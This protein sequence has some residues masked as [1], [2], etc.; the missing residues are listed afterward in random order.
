MSQFLKQTFASLVGSLAGLILFFGLGTSGLIFLIIAVASRDDGPQVKDKSVLV[1][2]LA[3]TITDT[4]P[5]LSTTEAIG[6]VLGGSDES[7]IAL[8]TLLDTIDKATKDPRITALYLDGTQTSTGP[9]AGLATLKEVRGALARFQTAG[10]QIIAYDVD[11]GEQEYYLTSLADKVILNPAGAIEFNGFSSQPLFFAGALEKF[12]IGVQIIR[13]GQYKAAVEPFTLKQMSPENR[14]QM[15]KL[16]GSLWYE[17]IATVGKSRELTPTQLQE[18]T[19]NQGL[20]LADEA[21]EKGLVDQLSYQDEVV[22]ELKALSG[23][24][25]EDESF[26]QIS[27][28]SYSRVSSQQSETGVSDN[29][30]AVV[31]AEGEIVSGQGGVNQVG[32]ESLARQL[33]ELRQDKAVKAVVLRVN[34]PGGS[35]TA[36]EVIEREVRLTQKEKPVIVSM[37][38]FA[39]SGGYWIV[40]GADYVFAEPNTVTGSIGVFGLL[41][42]VQ[43]LANNNGV[44]WDVVKTGRYADS[45]TVSRPKTPQEL[46]IAQK[47]VN[48]I[49]DQ[50]LE[51]VANARKLPKQQVAQIAQGRVWSGR[52]AHKIGLVDE[53]GGV[54]QAVQYAAKQAKLGDDWEL[55]QSSESGG[56]ESRFLKRLAGEE[57]TQAKPGIDPITAEFEKFKADLAVLQTMN[58]PR[59]VYARLPFNWRM[60]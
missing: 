44:T 6:E 17:F 13:V 21:L 30:I 24:Q 39:A 46:A 56:F 9:T 1:F 16:L 34:S 26:R 45:Q 4:D 60:E 27:L 8:L 53:L 41:P 7:R 15:E 22:T 31:Y 57:S 14:Q 49:Y 2:D 32:G 28:A 5:T 40:T 50:F 58:D 20:L 25:E 29:K 18:I 3:M 10:K 43:E 47:A 12:G 19:N 42:N 23:R 33:R 48:K 37:G 54:E 59:G 35:A 11:L 51:K 38:D 36:S 52:D 55:Q